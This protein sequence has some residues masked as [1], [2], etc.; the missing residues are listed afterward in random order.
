[1]DATRR[2]T[3]A[4]LSSLRAQRHAV[5]RAAVVAGVAFD[6]PALDASIAAELADLAAFDAEDAAA[7]A[8]DDVTAAL[9]ADEDRGTARLLAH[10]SGRGLST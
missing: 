2:R 6:T 1:M 5:H 3:V 4:R 9:E 7:D 8:L 10:L